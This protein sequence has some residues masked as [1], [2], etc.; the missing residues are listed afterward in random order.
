MIKTNVCIKSSKRGNDKYRNRV[1]KRFEGLKFLDDLYIK[2]IT[3]TTAIGDYDSIKDSWVKPSFGEKKDISTRVNRVGSYLRKHFKGCFVGFIRNF[4]SGKKGYSHAHMLVFS[5]KYLSIDQ[6]QLQKTNSD[7]WVKF[8]DIK[9]K[10]NKKKEIGYILKY[11]SKE[12]K[13]ENDEKH[14]LTMSLQ[15][16]FKKQSYSISK[17]LSDLISYR[18]NSNEVLNNGKYQVDLFGDFIAI[19]WVIIGFF[20]PFE[21]KVLNPSFDASKWF[22]IINNVPDPPKKDYEFMRY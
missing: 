18:H 22:S 10:K 15:W 14:A 9:G 17:A 3:I 21:I 13:V 1:F 19:E 7:A 2:H 5:W 11:L 20:L 8:R 6:E 12:I 16:L 4:E